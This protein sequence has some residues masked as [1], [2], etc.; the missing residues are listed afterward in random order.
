MDILAISI[1]IIIFLG[2]LLI[3]GYVFYGLLYLPIKWFISEFRYY[4]NN[5]P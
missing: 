5:T 2:F 1:A 3:M 4:W